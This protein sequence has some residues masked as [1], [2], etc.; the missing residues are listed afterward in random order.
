LLLLATAPL[1]TGCIIPQGEQSSP[2]R[3]PIYVL[4]SSIQPSPVS[5][6]VI[7]QTAPTTDLKF[8][9]TV[10]AEDA[11]VAMHTALYVDY[12]HPGSL[13]LVENTG[14]TGTLSE[15]RTLLAKLSNSD[16]RLTPGCHTLSQLVFHLDEW[17]D[18]NKQVV[19]TPPEL[20]MVTWLV[21]VQHDTGSSHL[22]GCPSISTQAVGP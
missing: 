5:V 15:P 11:G 4:A 7:D 14:G 1:A 6:L 13:F 20:A 17:D 12:N 22:S 2:E 3:S 16:A 19:G 21:D 18:E 10:Y 8:T 9:F